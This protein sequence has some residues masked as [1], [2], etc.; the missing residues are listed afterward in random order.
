MK[1]KKEKL[2]TKITDTF[3][4]SAKLTENTIYCCNRCVWLMP[5]R[6]VEG[7]DVYFHSEE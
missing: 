4:N 5:W 7:A 1:Y 3:K 6:K 2:L